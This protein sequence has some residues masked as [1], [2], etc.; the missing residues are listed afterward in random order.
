MT[1]I[2]DG[3]SAEVCLTFHR[4]PKI[5]PIANGS[6]M[7]RCFHNQLSAV[8]TTPKSANRPCAGLVTFDSSPLLWGV[9]RLWL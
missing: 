8:I 5:E 4:Q 7:M 1:T 9:E 6:N 3:K 2:D